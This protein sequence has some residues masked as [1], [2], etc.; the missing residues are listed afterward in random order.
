MALILDTRFLIA[1]SFPK[2]REER[3]KIRNFLLKISKDSLIIPSVVVIE[4]IKITGLTIGLETAKI[5]LRLWI[6]SG[7]E[8]AP[9]DK[10]TAFLAGEIA[11]Q[12]KGI[13]IADVIIGALAKRFKAT[14]VTDDP[15]F[16]I[17]N[18]KTLWYN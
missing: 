3:E 12:H 2:S 4:F 7:V 8:V 17:L 1:H 15:H 10:D 9:I 13:P 16:T 14:V 11:F 6:G 18:L 5:R